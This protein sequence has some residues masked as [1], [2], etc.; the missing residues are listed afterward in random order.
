MLF[1]LDQN[2]SVRAVNAFDLKKGEAYHLDMLILSF[3]VFV[4]SI[5]GLPWVCAATVQ[6]LTHV[7]AMGASQSKRQPPNEQVAINVTETRLSGLLTHCGILCSVLLLPWLGKIPMPVISGIFLFLGRKIMMG[8]ILFDRIGYLF[9]QKDK[10][11]P[12]E[13]ILFS[14][15]KTKTVAKYVFIQSLV[16]GL[17]WY[18]KQSS[19]LSLFFPSCIG[20]LI[21][22]R[23]FILPKLFTFKEL[24]LLDGKLEL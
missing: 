22:T 18:L 11:P 24:E 14:S 3:I 21:F 5:S 2:I 17:I 6:S 10:L 1:Y 12:K 16:L 15:L 8:N 20:F 13:S 23:T 7:R 9:C 19:S 4:L